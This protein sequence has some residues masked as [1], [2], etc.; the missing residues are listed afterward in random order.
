MVLPV[1][2]APATAPWRLSISDEWGNPITET[3]ELIVTPEPAHEP[4]LVPAP[5]LPPVITGN[6]WDAVAQCESGGDW[7][8]NTGN[9]YYGGLQFSYTTWLEHGGGVYAETANLAT[10]EQQI[11]IAE[12]VLANQGVG[13][14]PTCGQYLDDPMA[15]ENTVAALSE[16][17]EIPDPAAVSNLGQLAVD[18]ALSQLGDPYVYGANGPDAWDCSSLVQWAWGQAGVSLPR[19]T[20]DQVHSGWEVSTV[21]MQPGDLVFTNSTG[22]VG[23]YIGNGQVVQAPYSGQ[24]VQIT[25]LANFGWIE[26][27]RRVA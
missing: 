27:V 20:T 9:G 5:D 23:M 4:A 15:G 19:V 26:N 18:A 1:P 14:W 21:D 6:N 25:E 3:G 22:H 12:K 24:L 8:I 16:A 11:E 17:A 13:A 2:V 10:R 7:G